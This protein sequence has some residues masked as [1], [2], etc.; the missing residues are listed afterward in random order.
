MALCTAVYDADT[1]TP[2]K[3]RWGWW[4]LECMTQVAKYESGLDVPL[5]ELWSLNGGK[6]EVQYGVG[7]KDPVDGEVFILNPGDQLEVWRDR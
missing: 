3:M 5:L 6:H 7:F 4:H 1:T 2:R